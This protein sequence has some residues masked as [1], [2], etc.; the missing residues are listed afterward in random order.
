MKVCVYTICK[1]EAKFARRWMES[2]S[3]ADGVYVLDTG[4]TDGTPELLESL[5]AVVRRVEVN[6]WRFDT[7]RNLSLAMVPE[8]ADICPCIDLDE[9]FCP[10]WR[11][12]LERAWRPGTTQA[13]YEYV[14]SFDEYGRDDVVFY[15]EKIHA[16][17]GYVWRG[18]VHEIP[19]RASGRPVVVTAE[20]VRLEHRPDPT[21][22]RGQY[23]PL[24]EIAVAE[25]PEN[26]RNTHYLGREYMFA[27][28]WEDCIS[29]LR[30]HLEM[31]NAV[32]EDE[33]AASMRYIAAAY[34]ALGR[35]DEQERWLLR[36]TA[37]APWVREGWIALA[38]M[39]YGREA[40]SA[41]LACAERALTIVNRGATYISQG[42]CWGSLPHDLAALACWNLGLYE[43]A[44]S[45]GEAALAAEP[46]NERLKSN[47]NFYRLGVDAH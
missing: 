36:C 34:S 29:T 37:E 28:R 46:E 23:L 13:R 24:L 8:D 6:P 33:R 19:V 3:E 21:K 38:R 27:G 40:W 39:Y 2:M 16:R 9:S 15:A 18:A 7:A 26:D 47:L 1:N 30:H 31:P 11:E 41:C 32:W 14:W 12:A 22:S 35:K 4:S 43:A 5:G 45:H 42:E 17:K 10:G 25:E 44:L 20:G